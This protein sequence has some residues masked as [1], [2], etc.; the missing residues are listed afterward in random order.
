MLLGKKLC[1]I[2]VKSFGFQNIIDHLNFCN[3]LKMFF[4]SLLSVWGVWVKRR[5]IPSPDNKSTLPDFSDFIE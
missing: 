1:D 5:F 4:G 2:F 3:Q